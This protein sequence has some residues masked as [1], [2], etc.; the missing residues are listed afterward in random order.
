MKVLFLDVDGVMNA[1]PKEYS[2]ADWPGK[3]YEPECVER[4]NK[5]TRE[6]GAKIVLS[7]TWRLGRVGKEVQRFF[8]EWGVE[9]P[10][11]DRTSR[12]AG[13]AHL[14]RALEISKWVSENKPDKYVAVDDM[15]M[16]DLVPQRL[17]N[18]MVGMTDEDAEWLIEYLNAE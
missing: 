13:E 10:I 4:L 12:A 18:G 2:Y 15:N 5:I 6:T 9:S 16:K 14:A 11:Y 1:L 7:S 3:H 17:T 8:N